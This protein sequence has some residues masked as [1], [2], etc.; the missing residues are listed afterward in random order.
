LGLSVPGRGLP[1]SG[2]GHG[3]RLSSALPVWAPLAGAP[4]KGSRPVLLL[5][6]AAFGVH[7]PAPR[8]PVARLLWQNPRRTQ[9]HRCPRSLVC[10]QSCRRCAATLPPVP[11]SES[12]LSPRDTGTAY[13]RSLETGVLAAT[14]R[15]VPALPRPLPPT[16]QAAFP[17]VPVGDRPGDTASAGTGRSPAGRV[18]PTPRTCVPGPWK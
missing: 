7:D 13:F 3:G 10:Q 6:G 2:R 18:T 12:A 9:L 8:A 14:A 11:L 15:G 16:A 17:T 5:S 1:S 4:P